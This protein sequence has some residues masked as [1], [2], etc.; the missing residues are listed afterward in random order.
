MQ[1][2]YS[3]KWTNRLTLMS[4]QFVFG[5]AGQPL[6][7]SPGAC[8]GCGRCCAG[9]EPSAERCAPAARLRSSSCPPLLLSSSWLFM[10]QEYVVSIFIQLPDCCSG[11][12]C[13]VRT[14]GESEERGPGQGCPKC[15]GP[16]LGLQGPSMG[17]G[18]R[19]W[20]TTRVTPRPTS[21][22]SPAVRA[23]KQ[24]FCYGR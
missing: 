19:A 6:R 24:E 17:G 4:R 1:L 12:P 7:C 9:L 23:D 2:I 14:D 15:D 16:G 8:A 20:G 21:T 5:A 13:A 22:P 3:F 18:G 10:V 11:N